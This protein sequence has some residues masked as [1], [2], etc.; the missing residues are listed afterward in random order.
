MFCP[1]CGKDNAAEARFCND[2]GQEMATAAAEVLSPLPPVSPQPQSQAPRPGP[3]WQPPLPPAPPA[4]KGRGGLITCLIIVAIVAALGIL[5]VIGLALFGFLMLEGKSSR[6]EPASV[7]MPA[8]EP[9]H[10]DRFAGPATTS[11]GSPTAA[12]SPDKFAGPAVESVGG[13]RK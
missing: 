11:D 12:T 2:C 7:M 10:P 4:R 9:A 6:I 13:Q 3:Q 1:K 5:L 8:P